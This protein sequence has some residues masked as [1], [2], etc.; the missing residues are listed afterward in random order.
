MKIIS[1][2]A[3]GYS[4]NSFYNILYIFFNQFHFIFFPSANRNFEN[5]YE[6]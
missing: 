4:Q 3:A 5:S 1:M 6:R 2:E